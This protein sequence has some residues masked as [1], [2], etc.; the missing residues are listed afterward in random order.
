[1]SVTSLLIS[2]FDQLHVARESHFSVVME[3]A[4]ELIDFI[5]EIIAEETLFGL[6]TIVS[7]FGL[8]IIGLILG[9][10]F[11]K[12]LKLAIFIYI[13]SIIGTYFGVGSWGFID[14]VTGLLKEYGSEAIKYATLVCG[15]LP[16]GLGLVA[17]FIIG[18]I[19]G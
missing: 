6:P 19:R 1:M 14:R 18:L 12:A 3:M 16:L 8:F 7:M 11:R 5:M 15:V 17:G 10:V 13:I 9:I 2:Q 4:G